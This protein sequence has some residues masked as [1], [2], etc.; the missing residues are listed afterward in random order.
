M[1]MA[2]AC[3]ILISMMKDD[4]LANPMIGI[5]ET[6][7]QVLKGPQNPNLTCGFS[8]EAPRQAYYPV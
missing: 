6:S 7:L 3:E 2:D 1:R 5:D 8:G 4:I